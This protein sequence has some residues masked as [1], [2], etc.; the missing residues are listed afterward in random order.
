MVR[1][2][3][4]AAQVAEKVRELRAAQKRIGWYQPE[5]RWSIMSMRDVARL[6]REVAQVSRS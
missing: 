3:P 4:N 5:T 2:R 1:Q 6:R